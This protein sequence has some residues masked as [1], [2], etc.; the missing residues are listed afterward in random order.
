[1]HLKE[2]A[3]DL[4]IYCQAWSIRWKPISKTFYELIDCKQLLFFKTQTTLWGVYA[5]L[6]LN[7]FL[8]LTT[9]KLRIHKKS[10][11]EV[12]E[13][14]AEELEKWVDRDDADRFGN[15]NLVRWLD[16]L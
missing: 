13:N 9:A 5:A 7:H 15:P 14:L 11:P 4:V 1:M 6:L 2:L 12:E 8:L 16:L 10:E 3:V